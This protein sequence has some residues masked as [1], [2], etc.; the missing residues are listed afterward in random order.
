MVGPPMVGPLAGVLAL[1]VGGIGPAP[2]CGMLLADMGADVI[3]VERASAPA[4]EDSRFDLVNRGRRSIRLDLKRPEGVEV[5]LRLTDRADVLYEGYRP[6]VAERLGIGPDICLA[7]NPALVYGRMT[8][9]GQDGALAMSAGHDVNYIAISGALFPIGP[10]DGPPVAPLHHLGDY[11]GGAM[12]LAFGMLAAVIS[13]RA[14]GAGQV[15]DASIVD[16]TA[17]MTTYLHGERAAGRWSDTRGSNLL[18]G[19]APFYR[20]YECADGEFVAVGAI[21]PQFSA[22]L[23]L[24]IGLGDDEQVS[25]DWYDRAR[26]PDLSARVASIFR[27]RSRDEWVAL[28]VGHDACI[29]PVLSLAEVAQHPHNRERDAFVTVGGIAQP[30]PAPRLSATPASAGLPPAMGQHTEEVLGELGYDSAE[31]YDMRA[32]GVAV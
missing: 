7:R 2:Y 24:V 8:G 30:A 10:T 15:V 17:L 28:A 29:S 6:G 5:L 1:E 23:R 3:R 25:A 26:W 12:M 11:G 27:T 18:D 16:G 9:W 19:A 21:E 32:T 20:T 14:T 4:S 31:I 22:Q 13:S